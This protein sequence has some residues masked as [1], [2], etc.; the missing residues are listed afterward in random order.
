MGKER[1]EEELKTMKHWVLSYPWH[2]E[3]RLN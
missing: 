1:D 2:F 3:A